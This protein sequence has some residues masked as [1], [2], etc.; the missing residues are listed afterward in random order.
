MLSP[1]KSH[2]L[3]MVARQRAEAA[4]KSATADLAKTAS[5]YEMMLAGLGQDLA[6]LK[7]IQSVERKIE[8]KRG[9]IDKYRP[10]VDGILSA[11]NPAQDDI[12]ATMMVWAIDIGDWP[13]ALR[14]AEHVVRNDLEMPARFSRTA[15]TLIAEE[16]ADAGL[17]SPAMVDLHSLLEVHDLTADADMHDQVRAKL[18]KAIGTA[19]MAQAES[20]DAE[21]ESA[22][23]GGRQAL[24]QSA[25]ERL[26]R[27]LALNRNSGVKKSVEKL[28]REL[29]DLKAAPEKPGQ[30][31]PL[32]AKV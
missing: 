26:R 10:W 21:A 17:K 19:L 11:D 1:A 3:H 16:V 23:A 25:L 15:A 32:P 12:V 13:F 4:E 14:I 2:Y 30:K 29:R 24:L 8:A 27:A 6:R 9:M 20:F 7:I 22:P 18:E 28:E 31:K 5:R